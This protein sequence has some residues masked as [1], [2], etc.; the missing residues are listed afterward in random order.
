MNSSPPLTTFVEQ[1]VL[2]V[3]PGPDYATIYEGMLQ[4][5]DALVERAQAAESPLLLFDLQHTK[6]V[7]SAFLGLL[8]RVS[9]VITVQRQGRFGLCN[10][11]KFC[12]TIFATTKMQLHCEI[13]E[14]REEALAAFTANQSP[15]S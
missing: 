13:F 1:G 11:T 9:N 3:A 4:E 2:I 5:F 6:Y 12:K 10:L 8:L 14:T 7:G 15:S